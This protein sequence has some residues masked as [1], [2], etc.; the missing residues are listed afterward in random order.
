MSL[1]QTSSVIDQDDRKFE[2]AGELSS[3]GQGTVYRTNSDTDLV[4]LFFGNADALNEI[5]RV[6]RMPLSGLPVARPMSLISEPSGYTLQ[7]QRDMDVV[8]SM[9]YAY[10]TSVR[11]WWFDTGGL[12]RRLWL[13]TRIASV[14]ERLHC[15]G[16]VYGDVSSNNIMVSKSSLFTEVALIDLDN[17]FYFGERESA[18]VWTPTYSAPEIARDFVAPTFSTDDFSVAVVLFELLT[19]IH[20]FMDGDAVKRAPTSSEYF[21][22]AQKCLV[23]CV[24]DVKNENRC[25]SYPIQNAMDLLGEKLLA[26]FQ[27]TFE[28]ESPGTSFRASSGEFRLALA[29]T[30]LRTIVCQKCAWS[31]SLVNSTQCPDCGEVERLCRIR[32]ST[33]DGKV[34][35]YEIMLGESSKAIDLGL[36]FPALQKKENIKGAYLV[37]FSMFNRKIRVLPRHQELIDVPRNI[38][39]TEGIRIANFGDLQIEVEFS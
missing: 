39:S 20:P 11:D 22:L 3:G 19:M 38:Q 23:P 12:A 10:T 34:V 9:K 27:R 14:F 31:F 1:Q 37:D 25:S 2:L 7:F 35:A 17:L 6:R 4:K 18:E 8:R 28:Y 26:L 30:A 36:L 16:L 15:R 5:A 29:E 32:L 24:I 21:D 33:A 13:A